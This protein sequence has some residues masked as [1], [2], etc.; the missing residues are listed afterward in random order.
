MLETALLIKVGMVIKGIVWSGYG[1]AGTYMGF[2]V[3][4]Y[5]QDSIKYHKQQDM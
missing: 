5:V 2:A 1:L 4:R 3:K